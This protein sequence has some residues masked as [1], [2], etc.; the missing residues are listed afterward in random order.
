VLGN[1]RLRQN[2]PLFEGQWLRILVMS[3]W[4]ASLVDPSKTGLVGLSVVTER[5]YERSDI[6]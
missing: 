2:A 6:R 1:K 3:G 4:D 5:D